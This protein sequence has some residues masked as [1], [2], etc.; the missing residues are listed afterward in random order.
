MLIPHFLNFSNRTKKPEQ[1]PIWDKITGKFPAINPR[2]IIITYYP[3]I[4]SANPLDKDFQAH[5]EVHLEQQKDYEGGPKAWWDKYLSDLDF[6]LR[7]E[8]EAYRVQGEHIRANFNRPERRKRIM[9][10]A[11]DFSGSIYNQAISFQDAKRVLQGR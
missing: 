6:V 11:K 7:Q 9:Q 8:T 5:E 3:D 4:Y 2:S 1:C 10:I